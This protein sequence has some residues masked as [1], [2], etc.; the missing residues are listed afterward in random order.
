[1]K[2]YI[3]TLVIP[4]IF[5]DDDNFTPELCREFCNVFC[6]GKS[7]RAEELLQSFLTS[8]AYTL[9]EE[10]ESF[11]HLFLL[12]I[13]RLS[14]FKTI[15]ERIAVKGIADLVIKYPEHGFMVTEIKYGKSSR[16]TD[17]AKPASATKIPA[18]DDKKLDSCIK[19][20]FRQILKQDYLLP[21]IGNPYPVHTIAV[22]VCGRNHVRIKSVPAKEL[23]RNAHEFLEDAKP[24]KTG[25]V[26]F[27]ARGDKPPQNPRPHSHRRPRK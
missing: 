11:Y 18:K 3:E 26:S 14:V 12:A 4:A 24:R 19:A 23:I 13:F 5:Q 15:P 6:Q 16:K 25:R 22:V 20:A 9:H 17:T 21:Y 2:N 27:A 1:M 7:E 10:L 8:I